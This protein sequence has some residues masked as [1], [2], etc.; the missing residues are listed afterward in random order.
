MK[1]CHSSV[2]GWWQRRSNLVVGTRRR[3]F[4]RRPQ[5]LQHSCVL[6]TLSVVSLE[7]R[8]ALLPLKGRSQQILYQSRTVASNKSDFFSQHELRPFLSFVKDV[9]IDSLKH[10]CRILG[11]IVLYSLSVL[12]SGATDCQPLPSLRLIVH[13]R[14]QSEGRPP[15]SFDQA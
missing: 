4:V 6:S 9:E 3:N 10:P 1:S 8:Y 15:L 14:H 11:S 12:D 13:T 2:L 7:T 5:P